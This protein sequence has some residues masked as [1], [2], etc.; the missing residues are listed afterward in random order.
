LSADLFL[1]LRGTWHLWRVTR[2]RRPDAP[3]GYLVGQASFRPDGSGRYL[4]E[5]CGALH[6]AGGP[7]P[8]RRQYVYALEAATGS[9]LVFHAGGAER[10]ALL[11]RLPLVPPSAPDSPWRAAHTHGCGPDTY[12]AAYAFWMRPP[13]PPLFAVHYRV[14]GPHKDYTLTSV[15]GRGAVRAVD[16]SQADQLLRPAAPVC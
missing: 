13:R 5:E 6:L 8:V 12:V 11:H 3:S 4:Y 14:W 15:F 16:V 10:G 2:S 1:A 7:L 9:L